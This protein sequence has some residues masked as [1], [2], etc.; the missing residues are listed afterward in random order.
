MEKSKHYRSHVTESKGFVQ[1]HIC[2]QNHVR[3]QRNSKRTEEI[4]IKQLDLGR[5]QKSNIKALTEKPA[6][7]WLEIYYRTKGHREETQIQH[8]AC[9]HTEAIIRLHRFSQVL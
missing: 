2:N 9:F 8:R 3:R 1:K 7:G 5:T 6:L 4:K